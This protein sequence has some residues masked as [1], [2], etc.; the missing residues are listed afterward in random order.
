MLWVSQFFYPKSKVRKENKSGCSEIIRGKV[1]FQ[2]PVLKNE[3]S[4]ERKLFNKIRTY[5]V[6]RNIRI[7]SL[8]SITL[9]L[10][11]FCLPF[12]PSISTFKYLHFSLYPSSFCHRAFLYL[13]SSPSL[14]LSFFLFHFS[15]CS[16]SFHRTFFHL[17]SFLS[18]TLSSSSSHFILCIS[19]LTFLFHLPFPPL[20]SLLSPF[21][22]LFSLH[23]SLLFFPSLFF[24][25]P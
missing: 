5:E 18:L 11:L 23:T 14:T 1:I 7:L 8:F 16:L 15:L 24:L 6:D 17:L 12:H 19:L 10:Y 13:L 9:F 25:S 21:F 2:P 4:V 3:V 22:L 20:L